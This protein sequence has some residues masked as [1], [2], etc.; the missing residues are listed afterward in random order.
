MSRDYAV[1]AS[2]KDTN[3]TNPVING[4]NFGK[5]D[6]KGAV[7]KNIVLSSYTY[8]FNEAKLEDTM[9]E[10]TIIGYIDL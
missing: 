3:F 8:T 5:V 1:G 2:F 9:F 7:F 6:L 10:D 4:V